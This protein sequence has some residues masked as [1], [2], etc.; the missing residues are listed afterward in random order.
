M[1]TFR[2]RQWLSKYLSA[3]EQHIVAEATKGT[4]IMPRDLHTMIMSG[5]AWMITLIDGTRQYS[6]ATMLGISESLDA[7]AQIEGDMLVRGPSFWSRLIPGASGQ[8]LTS[9]G[10]KKIPIYLEA[11]SASSQ[12][13]VMPIEADTS[14]SLFATKGWTFVPLINLNITQLLPIVDQII[15]GEYRTAIY[16]VDQTKVVAITAESETIIA[17]S[18][19][20][21]V[22]V[23][24]F[25]SGVGVEAGKTYFVAHT[26]LDATPTTSSGC[27]FQQLPLVALPSWPPAKWARMPFTNPQIND[28]VEFNPDARVFSMGM[29]FG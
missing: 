27:K 20:E 21:E 6:M 14:A 8:V 26:R 28:P 22:Q 18:T 3:K 10:P 16:E 4:P 7:T 24:G 5:R 29:V 25:G 2:Q 15:T 1:E 11:A 12:S 19:G 13:A 23:F 17:A 9:Q